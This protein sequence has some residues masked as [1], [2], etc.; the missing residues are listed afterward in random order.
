MSLDREKVW[1]LCCEQ[2]SDVE[3]AY[4]L[5][6][7]IIDLIEGGKVTEAPKPAPQPVVVPPKPEPSGQ[8][9]T[10]PE[11]KRKG[12]CVY[13]ARMDP[14]KR[15]ATPE[16]MRLAKHVQGDQTVNENTAWRGKDDQ[17]LEGYLRADKW[18]YEAIGKMMGRSTGAIYNATKRV[19][20]TYWARMAG[21]NGHDTAS[22]PNL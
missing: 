13:I 3:K 8:A 17:E 19:R 2:Q 5:T 15:R 14:E 11:P 20:L 21:V 12:K 4:I 18:T 6:K 22:G 1:T 9:Q 16:E 10:P 7:N